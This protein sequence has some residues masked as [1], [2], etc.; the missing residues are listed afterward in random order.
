MIRVKKFKHYTRN[1]MSWVRMGEGEGVA[2]GWVRF[3][4]GEGEGVG[5]GGW[6][7]EG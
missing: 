7:C 5:E 1:T 3:G 4:E 6:V 2:R